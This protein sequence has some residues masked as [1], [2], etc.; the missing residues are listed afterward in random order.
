MIGCFHVTA[1]SGGADHGRW[2]CIV[3]RGAEAHQTLGLP[4]PLNHH[5]LSAPN[6]ADQLP[7]HFVD[8]LTPPACPRRPALRLL[9]S[10]NSCS[11]CLLLSWP[12]GRQPF[13]WR[14][15]APRMR[16]FLASIRPSQHPM[17]VTLRLAWCTTAIALV[18]SSRRM[19]RGLIFEVLAMLRYQPAPVRK[20]AP[21]I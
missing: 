2:P 8:F 20:V 7:S 9:P 6:L 5:S 14:A 16:D 11:P 15:M 17:A 19:S 3:T 1:P 10:P 18:M 21:P 4:G 12:K 13:C